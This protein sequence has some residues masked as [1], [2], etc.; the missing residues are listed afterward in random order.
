M[1]A[2]DQGT[3]THPDAHDPTTHEAR[4]T[5]HAHAHDNP[6]RGE[7]P[8]AAGTFPHERLDAYRVACELAALANKIAAQIPRGHRHIAD[9]LLR[10]ASNVVLLLAEGANRRGAGLKRQRFVESRGE[11]GEV[12]AAGDLLLAIKIGSRADIQMMKSLASREAA[13]LTGLIARQE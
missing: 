11:A 7:Q 8:A 5:C 12:A 13:M 4:S 2:D 3:T 1:Q 6:P 9:H 10:S